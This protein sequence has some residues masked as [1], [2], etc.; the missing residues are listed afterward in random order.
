MSCPGREAIS[1]CQRRLTSTSAPS[2]SLIQQSKPNLRAVLGLTKEVTPRHDCRTLAILLYI[3]AASAR[4]KWP[5]GSCVV[6]THSPTMSCI[7][8]LLFEG[9]N[10]L[11]SFLWSTGCHD[12]L[13][14]YCRDGRQ[15]FGRLDE[16]LENNGLLIS[17][18]LLA[19]LSWLLRC[20]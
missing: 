10:F 5:F 17:S 4:E 1:R 7:E 15:L 9:L 16:G 13:R 11:S 20:S 2:T 19:C 8:P 3:A 18:L 6:G 14:R 12:K